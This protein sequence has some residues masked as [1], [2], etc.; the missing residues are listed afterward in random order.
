MANTAHAAS[1]G[2]ARPVCRPEEAGKGPG[3]GRTRGQAELTQRPADGTR[4]SHPQT[5]QCE[6][7]VGTLISDYKC[8]F[9]LACQRKQ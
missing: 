2:A 1:S 7:A 4:R 3:M 5:S 6:T 9:S 8:Q